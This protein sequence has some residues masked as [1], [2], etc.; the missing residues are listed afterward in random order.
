MR[1]GGGGGGGGGNFLCVL[2]VVE[3]L[4]WYGCRTKGL[5]NEP[6]LLALQ[7]SWYLG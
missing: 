6:G 4:A 5:I 7:R 2:E 1:C 3:K